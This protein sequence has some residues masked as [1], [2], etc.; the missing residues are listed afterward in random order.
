M[1]WLFPHLK[2]IPF[3]L[4]FPFSQSPEISTWT[5]SGCAKY[6][7]V[8]ST[9]E[10]HGC[11]ADCCRRPMRH[12]CFA[13]I[14]GQR[15]ECFVGAA[16]DGVQE[17]SRGGRHVEEG[18]QDRGVLLSVRLHGDWDQSKL[19]LHGAPFVQRRI[20]EVSLLISP[21]FYAPPLNS[22]CVRH[23]RPIY[24]FFFSFQHN[25]F[26]LSFYFSVIYYYLVQLI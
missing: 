14:S 24:F 10:S 12:C 6:W 1:I 9:S 7:W 4:Q 13:A 15:P 21:P 5:T 22:S 17:G 18:C 20:P 16:G 2:N 8:P 25:F 26:L 19:I 3:V 23:L 11:P